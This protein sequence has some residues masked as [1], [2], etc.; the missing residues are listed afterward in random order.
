M[1]CWFFENA[2]KI[3]ICDDHDGLTKALE[4]TVY[5]L[6]FNT[7]Y[8]FQVQAYTTVGAGPYSDLINVTAAYENPVPQLLVATTD[9]VKMLDIDQKINYTLT[10][11]IPIQVSYSAME[12][13]IYWINELTSELVMS[14][15]SGTNVTKI[16][17]LNNTAHSLCVDWVA[18]Y[19]YWSEYSYKNGSSSYIMKLDLTMWEAGIIKY[20]N[21]VNT[22][23]RI[24]NLDIL[25]SQGYVSHA[26]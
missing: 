24:V 25:P 2:I 9:A 20:K 13:K 6:L 10:R 11:H 19:L 17:A 16:L 7:T 26:Q 3:E 4:Y 21:I 14:D 8:Y 22:D 1:Q 15:I 18:K 5:D 23:K 12:N